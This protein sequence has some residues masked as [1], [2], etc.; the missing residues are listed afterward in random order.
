M[1]IKFKPWARTPQMTIHEGPFSK[2]FR[3]GDEPWELEELAREAG[4]LATPE[5]VW[6]ILERTGLFEREEADRPGDLSPLG[7]HP[8]GA[9]VFE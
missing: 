1:K 5:Q 3:E 7:E 8:P 9:I 2:T 6:V 4:F